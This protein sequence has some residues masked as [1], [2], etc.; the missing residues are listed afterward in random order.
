M[1]FKV[2]DIAL[3]S[4]GAKKIDWAENRMP[5]LMK[6]RGDFRKR[7]PLDGI[8]ISA[9]LHVTK[10]TAVLAKTLVAGGAQ[11]RLTGSN[12]LS[13]QDDV[14]A[15]LAREGIEVFAWRG[16]TQKQYYWCLNKALDLNP[17]ITADDGADLINSIHSKRRSLI[18]NVFGGQEETT[19]GVIRLRAMAQAG[20]LRY[21]VIA[22]NDTPT[23]RMFD[24]FYGTGQSTIDGILR[25]TN[26][27]LA[28]KNFVVVGYGF[29]GK[30]IAQRAKGMGAKVIVVE[31][32][33]IEA[34]RAHMDGFVVFSM[35]DAAIAGDILVTATGNKNVI[36]GEHMK[37]MR[38]GAILANAGHFN[39]EISLPDLKKLGKKN[40]VIREN[41]VEYTLKNVRKIYLLAEGRLVNL[42]AAEGHPSEVMDMSFA[43]Q[44]LCC[45]YLVKNHESLENNVHNVPQEIDDKIAL[46]KLASLAISVEKL[47][48]EQ[49][50]YLA[51]WG[52]G[53]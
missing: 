49:R 17:Q 20:K 26:I 3:A 12:P 7:K 43:N 44:A 50:R 15:A 22:V 41:V 23:K 32:N 35:R 48:P 33:P 52:E 45:E 11:L 53:T 8:T 37:L 14:A 6:I 42:A 47:T 27:L 25:S 46:L 4:E 16:Q 36:R 30:G 2:K 1:S 39:A 9:C 13:T 10:E 29:C 18:K 31:T 34:L 19:T 5:V 24:N 21:P 28:G 51:S 40:R 38:D